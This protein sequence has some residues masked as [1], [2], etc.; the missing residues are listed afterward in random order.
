MPFYLILFG[1]NYK[2][3]F[4]DMAQEIFFFFWLFMAQITYLLT[5]FILTY[6]QWR[7]QETGHV[8]PWPK[9]KMPG[10]TTDLSYTS[11]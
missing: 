1:T 10:P 7:R 6:L 2:N 8:G 4:L 5:P 3:T 9:L 11:K